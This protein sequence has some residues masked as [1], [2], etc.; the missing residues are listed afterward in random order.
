VSLDD[1]SID[2]L[3]LVFRFLAPRDLLNIS[4]VNRNLRSSIRTREVV[5]S[6]LFHG[7]NAAKSIRN[8]IPLLKN[9]AI[10]CPSPMRL[11][12]LTCGKKCEFCFGKHVNQSKKHLFGTGRPAYVRKPW[13]VFACWHCIR[14]RRKRNVSKTWPYPCLTR[15]FNKYEDVIGQ[16]QNGNRFFY[17]PPV[18][19]RMSPY[20]QENAETCHRIF[21]HPSVL[22]Y[23]YG[24]RFMTGSIDPN[25]GPLS[26]FHNTT[27]GNHAPSRLAYNRRAVELEGVNDRYEIMCSWS[28]KDKAGE[29]IGPLITY[30]MVQDM[31]TYLDSS[32]EANVDEYVSSLITNRT[33]PGS[34]TLGA[35]DDIIRSFNLYDVESANQVAKRRQLTKENAY[36][37]RQLKIDR[38][39]EAIDKVYRHLIYDRSL[40]A[41]CCIVT[42]LRH[43][44]H[45]YREVHNSRFPC[46]RYG[47]GNR[48]MDD[49]FHRILAPCIKRPTTVTDSVA[50]SMA[51]DIY[52][53]IGEMSQESNM[54][55]LGSWF[56]NSYFENHGVTWRR[57]QWTDPSDRRR[58]P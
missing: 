28:F 55:P 31:V 36:L 3:G 54:Y 13:G 29:S 20:Y 12:R 56:P 48:L 45:A 39:M 15:A 47:T 34:N 43:F 51:I 9:K 24:L 18:V 16:L 8:M 52:F 40:M 7:G 2:I 44:I 32:Q 23:P 11:L 19:Q 6:G 27:F 30:D 4:Q 26:H 1:F 35:Y 53:S 57:A 25:V 42:R 14:Y 49:A 38:A 50:S 46:L 33:G 37:S 17:Q 21:S 41:N 58:A 5:I 10:Y 22:A